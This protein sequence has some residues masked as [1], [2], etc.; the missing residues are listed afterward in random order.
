MSL[1]QEDG[2]TKHKCHKCGRK[3]HQTMHSLE[4]AKVDYYIIEWTVGKEP[5]VEC[6]DC[7]PSTS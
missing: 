7:R 1:F 6:V 4:S 3:V 5:I 2:S